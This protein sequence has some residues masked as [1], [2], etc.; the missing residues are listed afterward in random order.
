MLVGEPDPIPVRVGTIQPD[1]LDHGRRLVGSHVSDPIG[2]YDRRP[3]ATKV[4][5]QAHSALARA[6]RDDQAIP[7]A[8]GTATSFV[9]PSWSKTESMRRLPF[10]DDHAASRRS[11]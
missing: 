8:S 4:D 3:V 10:L 11:A 1:S 9:E 6:C 5:P 2:K 7:H